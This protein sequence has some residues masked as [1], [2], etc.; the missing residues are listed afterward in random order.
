M[1]VFATICRC[2]TTVHLAAHHNAHC[3]GGRSCTDIKK[4][5]P[6]HET[7]HIF[8]HFLGRLAADGSI[9][10][11]TC[12]GLQ[13]AALPCWQTLMLSWYHGHLRFY[14]DPTKFVSS[15]NPVNKTYLNF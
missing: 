4:K 7:V 10:F 6:W 8:H 12:E 13:K 15:E 1:F 3:C 14:N 5:T 2:A 9:E 11:P